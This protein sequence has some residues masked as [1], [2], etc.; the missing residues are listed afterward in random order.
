MRVCTKKGF[1]PQYKS[2]NKQDKTELPN[3]PVLIK[4]KNNE[5]T[6]KI[7]KIY[8]DSQ[9]QCICLDWI[10]ASEKRAWPFV[11]FINKCT[12][13]KRLK[14][15]LNTTKPGTVAHIYNPRT[16]GGGDR[17]TS[18]SSSDQDLK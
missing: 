11:M 6:L 2:E 4:T 9:I 17:K 18:S 12:R 7:P 15:S 13:N 1:T 3:K 10:L 5:D 16:W 14:K 8:T